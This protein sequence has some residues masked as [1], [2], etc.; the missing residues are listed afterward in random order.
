MSD[1]ILAVGFAGPPDR[2]TPRQARLA[3][4]G[5][6]LLA[7]I[8]ATL[9]SLPEP[10]RSAAKIEWEYA[11]SI[12]RSSPLVATLGSAL[13]L[14]VEQLDSLFIEAAKL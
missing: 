1:M 8:D 11:V 7:S 4:L 5:A 12:E 9:E 2:I 6:G 13:G 3:L 10:Q 14:N